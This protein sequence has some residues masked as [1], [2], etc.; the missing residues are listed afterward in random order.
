MSLGKG[1]NLRAVPDRDAA[2]LVDDRRAAILALAPVELAA[3]VAHG[4]FMREGGMVVIE[5]VLDLGL[6]VAV[7]FIAVTAA[8]QLDLALRR[9]LDDGVDALLHQRGQREAIARQRQARE[10]E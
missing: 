8:R 4:R 6:P 3:G 5:D 1:D 2:V 9:T 7:E 10:D